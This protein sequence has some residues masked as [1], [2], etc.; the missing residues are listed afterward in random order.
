MAERE[1]RGNSCRCGAEKRGLRGAG[2]NGQGVQW[3]Q[4]AGWSF[5]TDMEAKAPGTQQP[6]VWVLVPS[7]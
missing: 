7:H 5:L 4:K 2:S 6:H 1:D 3:L